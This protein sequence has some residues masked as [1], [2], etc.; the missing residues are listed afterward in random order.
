MRLRPI[1]LLS[2]VLSFGLAS[3]A[4]A[5]D[6]PSSLDTDPALAGWWKF[7]ETTGNTFADSSKHGRKGAAL[8]KCDVGAF[9]IKPFGAGSLFQ[10]E[11]LAV[12]HAEADI[13]CAKC[14]GVCDEH[15]AG[16]SKEKVCTN[17]HGQHR[18][19]ERKCKWK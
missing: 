15:I 11:D 8:K 7:D 6:K 3:I 17:C 12:T 18:L 19:E 4:S 10:D 5:Q 2:L 16:E 13:G 14:H 1:V 9:G